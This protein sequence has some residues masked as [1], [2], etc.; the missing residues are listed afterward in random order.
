MIHTQM[1]SQGQRY[2]LSQQV[3]NFES[4]LDQLR[5]MM[6]GANMTKYLAKSIAV[7]EFGSNDYI[8]N[9]LLP[10]L[11]SSSYIYTPP[12]FANLLLNRYTQQILVLDLD[13]LFIYSNLFFFGFQQLSFMRFEINI[14]TL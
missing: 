8:N 11:Y 10:S 1:N 9:Y 5:P 7:L 14:V 3:L 4:T 2:S 6:S 13:S 12:A